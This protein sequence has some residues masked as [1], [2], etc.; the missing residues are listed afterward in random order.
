MKILILSAMDKEQ[1]LLLNFMGNSSQIDANGMIVYHGEIENHEV[2]AAKCGI[3]KVNA[4]LNTHR[5]I[6]EI[7]PDIVINSGVAGGVDGKLG[8]G[9]VLVPTE[10]AYHDVWCGPGT[11]IGVADGHTKYFTPSERFIQAAIKV[12]N[13]DSNIHFGVICSGDKFIHK[14]EEVEEIRANFPEAKAVDMESAAIA[15]A[16]AVN[17][18]PF[19][20]VR[21]MSDTPGQDENI[22]QYKDFWD[23]APERTFSALIGI[24]KELH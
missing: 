9:S 16:C 22:S 20:I 2:W 4:A 15:H 5:L 7:N 14:V 17:K 8:I 21:V 11:E 6:S 12:S 18:L 24:L 1:N 19:A 3:G 13:N 10:V 23:K